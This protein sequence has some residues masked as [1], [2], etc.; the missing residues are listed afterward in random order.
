MIAFTAR[1]VA[2]TNLPHLNSQ[3]VVLAED[4]DRDGGPRLEISRALTNT[5]QDRELGQDTYCLCTQTG[6]TVYGGV[7]SYS[8]DGSTLTM[9]LDPRAQEVLGVPAEFSIRLEADAATLEE[10]RAALATILGKGDGAS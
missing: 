2:A 3:V 8:L 4:P 9:Q 5:K 1:G 7:G 6:A 10:V